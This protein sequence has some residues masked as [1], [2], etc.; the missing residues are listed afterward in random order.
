MTTLIVCV[1]L[2]GALLELDTTY[3]FQLT[4][5]RGIIAGPLLGLATGDVMTGLQVGIFTELLFIDIS[6]LGG[7]LPPSAVVCCAVSLALC[8][9]SIPVYF[10]FFIGTVSAILFSLLEVF[11][12]KKRVEWIERQEQKI[13]QN[14]RYL[15]WT[16][17]ESL[18]IVF[19]LTFLFLWIVSTIT[20]HLLIKLMPY[21]PEQI[22]IASRFAYMA[23]PWIGMATL[24]PLF[25]LKTR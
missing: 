16:I 6:P 12:R 25:R 17:L 21:L 2:I 22:H 18:T 23:V 1:C 13:I 14:P 5:S 8:A 19:V 11:I 4:F 10:S 24:I 3:A 15:T 9:C 7:L 20:G